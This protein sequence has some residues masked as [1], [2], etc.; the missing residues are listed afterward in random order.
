MAAFHSF[1]IGHS[2]V[3]SLRATVARRDTHPM[4][5]I[6]RR[7][8]VLRIEYAGERAWEFDDAGRLV[9]NEDRDRWRQFT[10]DQ[11]SW[12]QSVQGHGATRRLQPLSGE[13]DASDRVHRA[14]AVACALRSRLNDGGLRAHTE[15]GICE[16][17]GAVA[18]A[19]LTRAASWDRARL[20]ED[21]EAIRRLLLPVPVLPPDQYGALPIQ[22]TEGC[23][24]D[25]CGFCTLYKGVRYRERTPAEIANL[26]DA[27]L[28][29]L[30]PS[31]ARFR[32]LFLGQ[33]NALLLDD[34]LLHAQLDVLDARFPR[35]PSGM[36]AADRRAWIDDR[37]GAVEGFAAFL[38]AFHRERPASRW[39]QLRDRGLLRVHI[40]V[41]SGS[42]R[43][44]NELGKP[45]RM[46][47][48]E[49]L[50]DALRTG[51]VPV[52]LIFLAG[53]GGTAREAEHLER[54]AELVGRLRLR[55]GDQIFVSPFVD[56]GDAAERRFSQMATHRLRARLRSAVPVGIP[57]AEYD[58]HLLGQRT[59]RAPGSPRT[60]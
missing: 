24:W 11:R 14:H 33:A 29:H 8:G 40:G 12:G 19:W 28:A 25:R 7:R 13:N 31:V 27:L 54:T 58:L 47:R 34:E 30:G 38:D 44:L 50:M 17:P 6:G 53:A 56:R 9:R 52:G 41:E 1:E 43:L 42:E 23:S 39:R 18:R 48:V 10:L 49:S 57:I 21:R 45:V 55:P 22:L 59:P 35:P 60:S 3:L 15:R 46:E 5:Q 37:P 4:W 16:D 26:V 51:G 2:P 20:R 32:R 36:G